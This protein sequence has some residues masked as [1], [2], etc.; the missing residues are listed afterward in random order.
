VEKYEKKYS[1]TRA[2]EIDA[3]FDMFEVEGVDLYYKTILDIA[4]LGDNNGI[5]SFYLH[6][7]N[8]TLEIQANEDGYLMFTLNDLGG[9]DD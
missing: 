3:V 4:A 5:K 7:D 1:G 9:S 8:E 2:Y 6:F